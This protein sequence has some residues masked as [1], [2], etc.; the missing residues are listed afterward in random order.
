VEQQDAAGILGPCLGLV[1]ERWQRPSPPATF[2]KPL[3]SHVA[4]IGHFIDPEG[5]AQWDPSFTRLPPDGCARFLEKLRPFA[6]PLETHRDHVRSITGATTTVSFIGIPV[7]SQQCHDALRTP[8]RHALRDLVQR[9]VDLAADEGCSVVGLGGYAAILTRNGKDLR[10]HGLAV[11]TGNGF[12]VGAGLHALKSAAHSQRI[13]W[14]RAS[15]AI[16]GATGNIGSICAEL[17]AREVGS[18]LLLGRPSRLSDLKAMASRISREIGGESR[19]TVGTDLLLCR[20]AQLIVTTSNQAGSIL[21]PEHLGDAPAV[22]I[23]LAVPSD[24]DESVARERPDVH[25]I[26]GGVIRTPCNPD[27]YVPGIPLDR[28]EMFACMTETVLMG[29]EGARAHGSYGSLS[30][31]RVLQTID[32]S[33]KHGFLDIR[34][35]SDAWRERDRAASS[36]VGMSWLDA[37]RAV[38]MP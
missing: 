30:V 11:T 22:I 20:G 14:E 1:A 29:F 36:R 38:A 26:R 24:V 15:A 5:V 32:L 12:T 19:I 9:A 33:R 10:P 28:G 16:V 2:K 3:P 27:W 6:E 37:S 23:D 35:N 31:D 18:V 4:F 17:L 8:E 7:S 25:V 21:F 13:I 34:L